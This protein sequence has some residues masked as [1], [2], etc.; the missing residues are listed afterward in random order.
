[1]TCYIERWCTPWVEKVILAAENALTTRTQ[2]T[3]PGQL[4]VH[5]IH[6]TIAKVN[7]IRNEF[8]Y[9]FIRTSTGGLDIWAEAT[10]RIVNACVLAPRQ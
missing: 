10:W 3:E 5:A 6:K 1:M 2:P 8:V 4:V 7:Y 9:V